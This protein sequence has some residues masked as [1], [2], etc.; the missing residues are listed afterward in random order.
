ME[1]NVYTTDERFS[2]ASTIW[3]QLGSERFSFATGCAPLTYGE[4]NGMVYLLMKVGSNSKAIS[5]FEVAYN[6]V[7]DIYEVSF[8]SKRFGKTDVVA[9]YSEVCG[10]MIHTLFK[11]HT[12]IEV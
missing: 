4:D 7:R 8:M 6:A 11:Q 5:L 12:G 2:L 3:R 9:N 1:T 10:D